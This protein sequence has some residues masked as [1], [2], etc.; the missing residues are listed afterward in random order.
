MPEHLSMPPPD[1]ILF[2]WSDSEW[3]FTFEGAVKLANTYPNT[4]LLLN[5]WGSVDAPDFA[6]FNADPEQL[7]KRVV[8]PERIRVLAPG[9][10]FTLKK[11]KK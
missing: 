11:L 8:N 10:P 7:K 9:E 4:L 1:A 3:H 2:D 6:P 5:H